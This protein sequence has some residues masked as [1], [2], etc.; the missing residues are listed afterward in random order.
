MSWLGRKVR[1]LLARLDAAAPKNRIEDDRREVAK[2]RGQRWIRKHLGD[3]EY[4]HTFQGQP[5][6]WVT[7]FHVEQKP[8]Y[9]AL[10]GL[11]GM[12]R[13]EL[14]KRGIC[15]EDID[16]A[17]PGHGPIMA[18]KVS[19]REAVQAQGIDEDG[20]YTIKDGVVQR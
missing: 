13:D 20:P 15:I 9:D 14:E 4:R 11:V 18:T 8:A 10:A 1:A 6:D 5:I 12:S 3:V 2:L 16:I 17:K 19:Y 7:R